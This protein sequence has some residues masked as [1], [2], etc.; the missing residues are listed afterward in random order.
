MAWCLAAVA[1]ADLLFGD[2]NLCTVLKG[3]SEVVV[4]QQEPPKD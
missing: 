2:C 3:R 4:L 1:V